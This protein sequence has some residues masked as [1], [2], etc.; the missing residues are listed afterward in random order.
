MSMEEANNGFTQGMR[1]ATEAAVKGGA[2][3]EHMIS[4][5]GEQKFRLEMTLFQIRNAQA[6]KDAL[7]KILPANGMP[8]LP[9]GRAG[10]GGE[11]RG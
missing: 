6:Q 5:L 1:L 7:G 11:M 9:P 10:G 4:V 8:K 3:L 2:S